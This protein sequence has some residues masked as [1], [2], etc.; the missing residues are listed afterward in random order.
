[1]DIREELGR[2]IIF[3]DGGLGSLLQE[4][5]LK[6]GELPETWNLTRPEVLYDIHR[7]YLDAG[8]DIILANTFGANGFK[9]D[10]LEE[11]V[12][13]A[14]VNAKKAVADS[15]RKAYVALDMGPTGKLLK[16][17]GTLDFEEC[18]SIYAD[19][20]RY[21]AKAGADLILIE[22]M[23]DT[24]ELK[25]AV[26][27]AK[28]NSNL[29]VVATVVFDEHHKMLTGA[30]PEVVVALLEG[31]RVDA[32]G[33]NC[34]LGPKQ[35]KPIF[36]TMARYAS[37]PLVITPNAG[38][39]RSE[40]GKTVYDV[41]PEEFAEDMEEII[42]MGAWM[43]GGCCG[44]TPAHIKALTERC[45]GIIPKPLTD[46]DYTIVTSYSTAVELGG[47]PVI[48]GE[49]INPTGKSKF[50]QAL[51][52]NNMEYILEE[53]VKQ[54]DSGAHILDVNVG[55]PEIDEPAMMRRTVFELQSV[56]PLPLQI[57]TTDPVAMEQA[58]RIY[59]G[60]PMINS[61]NGKEEIMHQIFPLVQKYGGTVVGLALDEAGIPDTA[62]G[63]LAVAKK[64]YDTAAQYGIKPKDIVIDALTMT[65]STDNNSANITLDT[66]REIK[67][68]GGRTVLGVS[69]ISFGLPQREVINSGFFLMAMQ[70]GLSA[71]IINPNARAM[72]QA[73]DT[74]CVLGGFD[75]QCMSYIEK[76][77]VA[78]PTP[79]AQT[80]T[81]VKQAGKAVTGNLSLTD[82]IVKGLKEQAYKATKDELGTKDTM[83]IINGELVPALDIVGKGFEKGTV[84]LPQLLMSAEA[85]KAGFEA[86]KEYVSSQGTNQ[87]KKATIVIA[88]VKGDIHDIGKN[89]VKVLLENYGYDVIDLG[90]D[91]PPETVVD[92]VIETHAP[93]V[94]LS[95]LMTTTVVSMEETIKKLHESAPWCK[96]MVG[97]AVL[98]QEYAD[99]IGADFYGKDAMQSVYYAE[100]LLNPAK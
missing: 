13:A 75:S 96:I 57:D 66:V 65:M 26:L 4:R 52:D 48:I 59:N 67:A 100:E 37:I 72:I 10:N 55:L 74:Y 76:Y 91:V 98:T 32:I 89:I 70:A 93:L 27:A 5:G 39:P 83:E 41:G 84:F 38:L 79:V 1:M 6:P 42:N 50:K 54:A 33:M 64:I 53:G 62:E 12:T 97:G 17:M 36:E 19:V 18:V 16:P 47:R 63:R 71:G 9:Y 23:S 30:T 95:A 92:K 68:H 77:A 90:K 2:R 44:T 82:C 69:N 8:A 56:L 61:V 31:L 99:M 78:E 29:P 7:A 40:N 49:R 20:V 81:S 11:I 25:A 45:C 85:A 87:E 3:F 58:M 35:M 34:G 43:A 73:Y 60:K 28:E 14:V 94:G 22:T 46:K 88:T 24:Y 80:V 51:R 21:G 86:I 15:G